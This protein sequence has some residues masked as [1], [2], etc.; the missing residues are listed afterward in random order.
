LKTWQGQYK[1]LPQDDRL[2]KKTWE[3]T[4]VSLFKDILF[5]AR[6]IAKKE[7]KS[8]LLI[9]MKGHGPHWMDKAIWDELVDN[10]WDTEGWKRK[11]KVGHDNRLTEKDGSITKHT[12]G[13]IPFA[14]SRKRMVCVFHLGFFLF[15]NKSLSNLK[16][17]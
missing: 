16:N 6:D 5:K 14:L 13:S 10:H 7:A 9:N 8:R 17:C 11:S 15:L 1:W 4:A 2:V 12:G 3:K